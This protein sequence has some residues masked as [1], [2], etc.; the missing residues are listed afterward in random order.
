MAKL[1]FNM[2]APTHKEDGSGIKKAIHYRLYEND[3]LVLDDIGTLSFDYLIDE[4]LQDSYAFSISSVITS[5]NLEG[6]K[7]KPVHVNFSRPNAP[8]GITVSIVS[9]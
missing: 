7:S 6:A 5:L 9:S 1:T 8:S 4:P 2:T 3:E